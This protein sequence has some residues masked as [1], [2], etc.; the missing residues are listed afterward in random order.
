M[1]NYEAIKENRHPEQEMKKVP[2]LLMIFFIVITLGF[3]VPYWYISRSKLLNQFNSS[4]KMTLTPFVILIIMNIL[5]QIIKFFPE[6]TL[7]LNFQIINHIFTNK[8]IDF[9]LSSTY[10]IIH[11]I[12]VFKVKRIIQEHFDNSDDMGIELSGVW[13]FLFGD[14]YLQYKINRFPKPLDMNEL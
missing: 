11:Y 10:L 7:L 4:K 14:Y 1:K 8:L 12:Q 5:Q 3:Y 6:T 2:I 13:T 9:F